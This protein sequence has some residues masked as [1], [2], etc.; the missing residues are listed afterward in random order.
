MKKLKKKILIGALTL[1]ISVSS[2]SAFA[3]THIV[4]SGDTYWKISNWYGV[5]L[6]SLLKANNA[7]YNSILYIGDKV[8]IPES[9]SYKNHIVQ[10]GD[11]LWKL[12]NKYGVTV[13]DIAKANN[14]STSKVLYVGDVLKIP[15]HNIPIKETPGPQYGELLDWWTEAQYIIPMN[16]EFKV[17]DFYTGKS[18]KVKRTQGANHIDAETLTLNDTNIMK[19]VWGGTLSW[20]RRPVLIEYN[21]RK[22]A[23]SMSSIPHAGNEKSEGGKYTS[24]RSGGYGAGTNF[25]YIKGNGID[26]H[27]DIHFLNSTRH[28]D[29]KLDQEHQKNVKIAAGMK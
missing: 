18:F 8:T 28:S 1:T 25:D 20:S 21:G 27:F 10:K 23:A 29:G 2:S 24:W 9:N 15:V 5:S 12:S 26:G 3:A 16:A 19:S 6:D 11:D 17:V 4:K 7:N 13:N 22:I 14:I